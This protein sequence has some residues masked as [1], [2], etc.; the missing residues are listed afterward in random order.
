MST[1]A[2][3]TVPALPFTSGHLSS[4]GPL[5]VFTLA[6]GSMLA[7]IAVSQWVASFYT[8]RL[9]LRL[10]A[11]RYALAAAGWM[12]VH[13]QAF[14]QGDELPLPPMIVAV[15]LLWL[16]SVAQDVYFWQMRWRRLVGQLFLAV[17]GVVAIVG[18]HRLHPTDPSAIYL[19]MGAW[20]LG[21]SWQAW[22]A[23]LRERN[24]G[25][26]LIALASLSYPVFVGVVVA[27]QGTV[28]RLELSYVAVI[29]SAI[30]GVAVLVGS[31]VRFGQ[32]LET[33]LRQ[34]T[35]GEHRLRALN[36]SLEESVAQR[37]A[38][39]R[40]VIEGL[41]SFTRNVSHDL[42]S[43]L[44]GMAGVPGWPTRCCLR[45]RSSVHARCSPRWPPRPTAWWRWCVT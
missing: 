31:L 17:L 21:L 22:R 40:R 34:L 10:F 24:A 3:T 8:D 29:P 4:L 14:R 12:T 30:M 41:E 5:D 16:H 39:L 15:A 19:V 25:H 18:W 2:S 32:R 45:A 7:I 38:D 23:N 11:L 36:A 9:A 13:P 33:A 20:M 28:Q 44:A 27:L 1:A 6:A 37:T 35:Q 43:P 42:R 26:L